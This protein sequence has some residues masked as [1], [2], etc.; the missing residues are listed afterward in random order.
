M[1]STK[2]FLFVCT[3]FY[4]AA[5]E[6]ALGWPFVPITHVNRASNVGNFGSCTLPEI[7]F[8]TGFDGRKETSFE[9]VDQ[10]SYNH[11]SAQNIDVIT[12]FMCDALVN[13]CG[14][15]QTAKDTCAKAK[16]AA[17]AKSAK[18]GQQA[19]AFNAVFGFTTNFAAVA[20]VDDQGNVIGNAGS[21]AGSPAGA[22]PTSTTSASA[23][24]CT[25]ATSKT[26]TQNGTNLQLFTG[27]L[28][29]IAPPAVSQLGNGQFQVANNA[30][31][32]NKAAALGRSCSVQHN[33]CADAANASGN[34]GSFTVAAC[35]QQ[36]TQCNTAGGA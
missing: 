5:I 7:Q 21:N 25:S 26:T 4:F 11:N 30:A 2:P 3:F 29:G 36:E 12:G 18:T 8:A 10:K 27:S 19:D 23:C 28:G 31:F 1:T 32:K 22:T 9:P 35:D 17:D 34:K 20:A 15:D 33:Q 13:T 6:Q 14:A 16:T 24:T